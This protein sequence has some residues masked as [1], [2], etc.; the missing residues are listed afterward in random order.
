MAVAIGA[1][2]SRR[3]LSGFLLKP[4]FGVFERMAIRAY[5]ISL[6]GGSLR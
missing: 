6:N 1:A 3:N 4:D 2:D 5:D